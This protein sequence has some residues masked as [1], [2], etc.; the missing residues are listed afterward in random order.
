[1]V[2]GKP[3]Q[4]AAIRNK[5]RQRHRKGSCRGFPS[6][7]AEIP[8]EN[9][10]G[11]AGRHR[12][13]AAA[14]RNRHPLQLVPGEPAAIRNQGGSW[15]QV[16]QDNRHPAQLQHR[17][18]ARSGTRHPQQGRKG[19]CRGFSCRAGENTRG[20]A[21]G[22][23]QAAQRPRCIDPDGAQLVPGLDGSKF[24]YQHRQRSGNQG[25]NQG[26]NYQKAFIL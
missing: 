14:I 1:M 24:S 5:P 17:H 13:R 11:R 26:A 21:A 6:L 2:P 12:G 8:G 25:S 7:S 19:S 18:P 16:N 22:G 15:Y 4:P 10:A 9:P 20:A 23:Q 3:G